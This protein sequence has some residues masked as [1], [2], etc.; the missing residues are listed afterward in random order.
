MNLKRRLEL[1]VTVLIWFAAT[2]DGD[3]MMRFCPAF[4]VVQLMRQA[5]WFVFS[6]IELKKVVIQNQ[7]GLELFYLTENILIG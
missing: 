3:K 1:H 4:H 7:Y 5:S 6:N 2:G